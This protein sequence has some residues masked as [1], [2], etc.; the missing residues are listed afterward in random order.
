M[1]SRNLAISAPELSSAAVGFEECFERSDR[2][3]AE[4]PFD[5]GAHLR[6]RSL[7]VAVCLAEYLAIRLD[8]CEPFQRL[9]AKGAGIVGNMIDAVRDPC[10]ALLVHFMVLDVFGDPLL[11]VLS[12]PV[13]RL[14]K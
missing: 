10:L 12:D 14:P 6:N 7:H 5:D 13:E 2:S 4:V 3:I 1:Q 9:S 8:E 11:G